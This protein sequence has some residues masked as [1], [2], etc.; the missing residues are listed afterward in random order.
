MHASPLRNVAGLV[1]KTKRSLFCLD[2]PQTDL[3]GKISLL[4]CK[5]EIIGEMLC[6]YLRRLDIPTFHLRFFSVCS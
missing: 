1:L 4:E 2:R 5:R 3:R 6:R